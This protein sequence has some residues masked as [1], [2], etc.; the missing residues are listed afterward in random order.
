MEWETC[1]IAGTGTARPTLPPGPRGGSP[2]PWPRLELDRDRGL[3]TLVPFLRP[4]IPLRLA[5]DTYRVGDSYSILIFFARPLSP[6]FHPFLGLLLPTRLLR[7]SLL[8]RIAYLQFDS[9]WGFVSVLT[10]PVKASPS[11]HPQQQ[12]ENLTPLTLLRVTTCGMVAQ[13][14]RFSVTLG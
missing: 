6:F 8:A 2:P 5:Y 11:K 3:A 10:H 13:I 12:P 4:S 1:T 14:S 9:T 7:P